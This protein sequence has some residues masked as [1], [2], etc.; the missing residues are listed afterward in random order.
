MTNYPSVYI[1]AFAYCKTWFCLRTCM[2]MVLH[3]V[4]FRSSFLSLLCLIASSSCTSC[5][6]ACYLYAA[7]I[8]FVCFYESRFCSPAINQIFLSQYKGCFP[9]ILH[10]RWEKYHWTGPLGLCIIY[11]NMISELYNYM[12]LLRNYLKVINI[13]SQCDKH[14]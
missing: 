10:C 1:Q 12:H 11:T 9:F 7:L 5:C 3:C 14:W 8:F 6:H 2:Q 4:N 13:G